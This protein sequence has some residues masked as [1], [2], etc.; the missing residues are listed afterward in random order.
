MAIAVVGKD[1]PLKELSE[2]ETQSYL[3]MILSEERRG[4]DPP[5]AGDDAPPPPPPSDPPAHPDPTP[6]VAMETQ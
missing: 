2:T 3:D 4:G 5:A 1:T 6:V